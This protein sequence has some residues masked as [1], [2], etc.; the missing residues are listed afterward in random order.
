[1]PK[2]TIFQIDMFFDSLICL[3][4]KKYGSPEMWKRFTIRHCITYQKAWILIKPLLG[5]QNT[6]WVF[7][8]RHSSVIAYSP[9]IYVA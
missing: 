9:Y 3:H 5:S 7:F 8:S 2:L 4:I 1:M 6:N